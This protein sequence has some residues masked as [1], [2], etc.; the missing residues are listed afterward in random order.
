MYNYDPKA[1][2]EEKEKVV[3]TVRLLKIYGYEALQNKI[4]LTKE[5]AK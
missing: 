2:T 5:M 4:D 3:N 1:T